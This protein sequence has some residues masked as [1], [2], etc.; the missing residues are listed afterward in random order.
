MSTRRG[1]SFA[2]TVLAALLAGC[3]ASGTAEVEK[4]RARAAYE[5]GLAAMTD[6]QRAEALSALQEAVAADP[7][8]ARYH[9]GLGLLLLDLGQLDQGIERFRKAIELEPKFADGHFHLGTALAEAK[10]WEEAVQSYRTALALPTLTVPD[11]VH[12]NLGLALYNLKRYREAEQSLRFALSLDPEMQTAYYNLG[13]VLVAEGRQDEAK[14]AFR[15]ARKLV[16]ESPVGQAA[17]E[18]LKELGEES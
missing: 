11:F 14:Q 16:P 10:R 12:Q 15:Q 2:L 9:D 18:R 3:A 4:L 17:R 5:R 6:R 13:L 7:G 8:V 1:L